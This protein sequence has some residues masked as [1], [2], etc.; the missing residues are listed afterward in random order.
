M[1]WYFG[2]EAYGILASWARIKPM[3]PA[4]EG[5][6]LTTGLLSPFLIMYFLILKRKENWTW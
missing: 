6:L 2:C 3:L 1:L 5:E 4:L